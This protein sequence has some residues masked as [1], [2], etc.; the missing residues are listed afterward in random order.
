MTPGV[1]WSR[2]LF[3]RRL[4]PTALL[5]SLVLAATFVVSGCET[6]KGVTVVN[7]LTVPIEFSQVSVRSDYTGMLD[8]LYLDL[9][10]NRS[11]TPAGQQG[12]LS[13]LISPD[14]D[15]GILRKYL[16]YAVDLSGEVVYQ[17][18]FTWDELNDMG[19]RVEIEPGVGV[20]QVYYVTVVNDNDL[21]IRLF[22]NKGAGDFIQPSASL[23][24]PFV[25]VGEPLPFLFEAR[26]APSG[27]GLDSQVIF[28]QELTLEQLETQ[29]WTIVV[30]AQ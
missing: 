14:R 27:A 12:M 13:T 23:R 5:L 19:W 26:E 25:F 8:L 20:D 29:D 30:K 21:R 1:R 22:W 2:A 3:S 15:E 9:T 4:A 6:R 16:W 10:D 18:M 7:G 24:V 28:S 17:K 11:L